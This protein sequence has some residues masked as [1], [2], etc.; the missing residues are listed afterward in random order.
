MSS[1]F[2]SQQSA[3]NSNSNSNNNNNTRF[4]NNFNSL[5]DYRNSAAAFYQDQQRN[6]RPTTGVEQIR[7]DNLNLNPSVI[8]TNS[9]NLNKQHINTTIVNKRLEQTQ[10]DSSNSFNRQVD[11]FQVNIIESLKSESL[12]MYIYVKLQEFLYYIF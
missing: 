6:S 7:L 11:K 5:N 4:N 2:F 8:N 1:S 9:S 10:S 12:N 3:A